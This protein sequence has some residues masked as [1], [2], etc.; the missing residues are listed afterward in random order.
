MRLD[1]QT[2]LPVCQPNLTALNTRIPRFQD[3]LNQIG[4]LVGGEL[5]AFDVG[6][7]LPLAI[8]DGCVQGMTHEAFIGE[9]ID[10][11]QICYA[12]NIRNTSS[13]KMPGGRIR[14]PILGVVGQFL[15][16][17]SLWIKGHRQQHEITA[18][19]L[20]EMPLQDTKIV[21]NPIA[22]IR[23]GAACVNEIQGDYFAGVLRQRDTPMRLV[24]QREIGH[25]LSDREN[26]GRTG[27]AAEVFQQL[28]TA[29]SQ[30]ILFHALIETDLNVFY[31][32]L[33]AVYD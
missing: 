14:F 21:G 27:A 10:S 11:E 19:L 28:Q 32:R 13:K 22:E 2:L 15:G 12:L 9:I 26:F 24:R 7:E 4:E 5:I 6:Y 3:G 18:E 1:T 17:V 30:W 16:P 20:L 23:Q 31:I 29:R 8:N 25:C 33:I